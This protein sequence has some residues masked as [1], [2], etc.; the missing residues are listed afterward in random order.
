MKFKTKTRMMTAS[1]NDVKLAKQQ[2]TIVHVTHSNIT[3]V[4]KTTVPLELDAGLRFFY[5]SCGLFG[6]G[7]ALLGVTYLRYK[8]RG[9]KSQYNE[10]LVSN[11][12][13]V[14]A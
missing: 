6:L 12:Q 3:F 4:A 5:A 10:P 13:A 8:E 7:L 11:D 14:E 2:G 1:Y 9:P